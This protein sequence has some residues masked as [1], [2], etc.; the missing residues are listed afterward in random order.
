[1]NDMARKP[2]GHDHRPEVIDLRRYRQ[3]AEKQRRPTAPPPSNNRGR[4]PGQRE[5]FLGPRP[6]AGTILVLV[7]V[8]LLA[9]WIL[10][11]LL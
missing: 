4:R 2:N 3:A 9:L 10:P 1:M 7:L 6:N 11:T 8:V 5:P